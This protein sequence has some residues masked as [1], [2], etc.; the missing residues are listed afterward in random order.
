MAVIRRCRT[1]IT[2][3]LVERLILGT[4]FASRGAKKVVEILGYFASKNNDHRQ[5]DQ[6][7]DANPRREG[8]EIAHRQQIP[9]SVRV[10]CRVAGPGLRLQGTAHRRASRCG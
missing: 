4:A 2:T 5:D 3:L 9:N 1:T 10:L 6:E 7:S 8:R